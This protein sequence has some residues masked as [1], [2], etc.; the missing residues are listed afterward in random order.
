MNEI[1][2]IKFYRNWTKKIIISPLQTEVQKGYKNDRKKN[3]LS[4]II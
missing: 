1:G 4:N 2:T 3:Y